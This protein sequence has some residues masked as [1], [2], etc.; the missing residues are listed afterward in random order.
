VGRHND[1]ECYAASVS[2][3]SNHAAAITRV[4]PVSATLGGSHEKNQRAELVIRE[5][6]INLIDFD[7]VI[8]V[9]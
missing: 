6:S 8:V 1:E 7:G 2:Y 9:A 5:K 4:L 3:A